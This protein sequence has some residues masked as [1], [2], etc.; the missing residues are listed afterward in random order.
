LVEVANG[1]IKGEVGRAQS[2]AADLARL[3]AT[4]MTMCE[5][6]EQSH[7]E[8]T[9]A[10]ARSLSATL[11]R[12]DGE[13]TKSLTVM[14]QRVAAERS[15]S[16]RAKDDV[17]RFT[18]ATHELGRLA[19]HGLKMGTS[20]FSI[21]AWIKTTNYGGIVSDGGNTGAWWQFKV[22]DNKVSFSMSDG[23]NSV[24]N[25][26]ASTRSCRRRARWTWP[27]PGKIGQVMQL[28]RSVVRPDLQT[29]MLTA[30]LIPRSISA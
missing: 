9:A 4:K 13:L 10:K 23:T 27:T 11:A 28:F 20:A 16:T 15:A 3:H 25:L 18:V 5:E 22:M 6:V 1:Q 14:R 12:I 30:R 2:I 21:G 17:N 29:F 7:L 26:L 8:A 19:S 24:G